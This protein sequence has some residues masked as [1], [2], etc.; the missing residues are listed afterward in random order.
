MKYKNFVISFRDSLLS[1]LYIFC[2]DNRIIFHTILL[3]AGAVYIYMLKW[4]GLDVLRDFQHTTRWSE[5][6]VYEKELP[7][8]SQF[9]SRM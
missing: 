6:P 1:R 3:L 9:F 5:L 2:Q 4:L 7:M 8:N